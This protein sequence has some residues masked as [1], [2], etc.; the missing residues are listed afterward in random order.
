[1]YEQAIQ[2]NLSIVGQDGYCLVY[3]HEVFGVPAEY[4]SATVAWQSAQFPHP[5]E[6]PPSNIAVPVWFSYNGPD[7][8][9]AVWDKGT[10]YSTSAQGDKTFP[11]IQALVSWMGEGMTYLGWSE[12]IN[13]VRVVQPQGATMETFNEGDRANINVGLFGYDAGLFKTAVGTDWKTAIYAILQSSDF[14]NLNTVNQG[15][16]NNINSVLGGDASSALGQVWKTAVYDYIL[17]YATTNNATSL[18]PG[19]YKVE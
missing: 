15:D 5:G 11:S 16:V 6:T 10:I 18:A 17:K 1:M 14:K 4:P 12:D 2:P 9:V 3:V 13:S 7:G 19:L 8:H